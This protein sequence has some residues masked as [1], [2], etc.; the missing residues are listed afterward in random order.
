MSQ[1]TRITADSS[2]VADKMGYR[3]G[4]RVDRIR[5]SA[6]HI[7]IRT[8]KL[9]RR[10]ESNHPHR[11]RG[12]NVVDPESTVDAMTHLWLLYSDLGRNVHYAWGHAMSTLLVHNCL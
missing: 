7:I 11:A 1:T 10:V 9:L 5:E 12:K 8:V 3:Y 2:G 6:R 4:R